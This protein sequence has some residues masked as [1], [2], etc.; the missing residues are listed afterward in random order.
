MGGVLINIVVNLMIM[1]NIIKDSALL[2]DIDFIES[3][4]TKNWQRVGS[5]GSKE[6]FPIFLTASYFLELTC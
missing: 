3:S 2:G 1:T 6:T 5:P 4:R